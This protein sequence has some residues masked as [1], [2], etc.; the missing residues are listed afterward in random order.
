MLA[1]KHDPVVL[2]EIDHRR[3]GALDRADL[4]DCRL[5]PMEGDRQL[6]ALGL[7]VGAADLAVVFGGATRERA[8]QD[9][10]AGKLDLGALVAVVNAE[11]GWSAVGRGIHWAAFHHRSRQGRAAF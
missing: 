10:T 9:E 3:T 4:K 7:V 5:A 2:I 11:T 8:C 6:S 1:S